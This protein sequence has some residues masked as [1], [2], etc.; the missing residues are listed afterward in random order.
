MLSED[1]DE[2]LAVADRIVVLHDGEIAGIV[3]SHDTDRQAVGRLMLE[4]A[5]P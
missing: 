1:I 5:A 4:G 3:R 2:L